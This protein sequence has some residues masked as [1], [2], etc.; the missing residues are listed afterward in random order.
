MAAVRGTVDSKVGSANAKAPFAKGITIQTKPPKQKEVDKWEAAAGK[1]GSC[2]S[3]VWPWALLQAARI[4]VLT[5]GSV[6]VG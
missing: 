2:G 6:L 1:H 4:R 5:L 3:R